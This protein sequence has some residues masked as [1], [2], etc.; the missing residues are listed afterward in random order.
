ML[1][2]AI[3]GDTDLTSNA[4]GCPCSAPPPPC[5]QVEYTSEVP[6]AL[7]FGTN[8]DGALLDPQRVPP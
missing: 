5:R 1:F 3:D 6:S 8:A 4:I 2:A 7:I